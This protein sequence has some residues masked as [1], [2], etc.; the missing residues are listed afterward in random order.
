M[1]QRE[2]M[3]MAAKNYMPGVHIPR[4]VPL[5]DEQY[6]AHKRLGSAEKRLIQAYHYQPDN[7]A[8]IARLEATVARLHKAWIKAD[9][10]A[11]RP[12]MGQNR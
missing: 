8:K 11:R 1:G 7:L 10:D 2:S 6:R 9:A 12:M 3:I 5:T 4:A